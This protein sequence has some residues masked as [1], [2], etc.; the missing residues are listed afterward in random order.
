M[1]LL[2]QCPVAFYT[3]PIELDALWMVE[4]F[5]A[6]ILIALLARTFKKFK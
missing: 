5:V 1:A 4:F 2:T 6:I 3:E